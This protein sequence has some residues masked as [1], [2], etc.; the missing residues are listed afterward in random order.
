MYWWIIDLSLDAW[1]VS[2]S[3]DVFCRAVKSQP[4]SELQGSR[5]HDQP[6][7][8]VSL[9]KG[10]PP[11]KAAALYQLCFFWLM[12]I[13]LHIQRTMLLPMHDVI[14]HQQQLLHSLSPYCVQN[15]ISQEELLLC[16]SHVHVK[17]WISLWFISGCSVINL[18]VIWWSYLLVQKNRER[19]TTFDSVANWSNYGSGFF[20]PHSRLQTKQ[21]KALIFCTG[22]MKRCICLGNTTHT[23]SYYMLFA[24]IF[25]GVFFCFDDRCDFK[26]NR[27]FF[28]HHPLAKGLPSAHLGNSTPHVNHRN[29]ESYTNSKR[30]I[31]N[32]NA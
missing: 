6:D 12:I 3:I 15:L 26:I 21:I 24:I 23:L 13:F 9:W 20:L 2:G 10:A 32:K 25:A 27:S 31:S 11:P 19:A 7:I 1:Q 22:C 5:W 17:T 30:A 8:W 4:C 14:K 28:T 29:C 16:F 18:I